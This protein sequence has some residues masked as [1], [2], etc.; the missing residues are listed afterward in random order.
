LLDAGADI[1]PVQRLAGHSRVA[2]TQRY[3]L[4]PAAT[5]AAAA[6]LLHVPY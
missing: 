5:K 2:T 6:S 4:R 1:S 3:A